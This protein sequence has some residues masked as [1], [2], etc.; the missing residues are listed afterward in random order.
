MADGKACIYPTET[1]YGLGTNAM[2]EDAVEEIYEIKSRPRKNKLSCIVSS[3]REAE[4]YCRLKEREKKICEEFMPGPLTLVVEKREKVPDLLN[5][6][7]AFRVSS[8]DIGRKL[9]EFSEVP[10]VSTSANLSGAKNSFATG[11]IS[12]LVKSRVD[13]IID[14]GRLERTEPSSV[15]E[16]TDG[17]IK[18]WRQGEISKHE[19][20]KV[21]SI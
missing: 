7:F 13:Y 16:L 15:V 1:C 4:E 18:V 21:L 12:R 11:D 3:I 2:D 20:E 19:I 9:C 14:V 17:E 5:D 8:N 10:L 6:R